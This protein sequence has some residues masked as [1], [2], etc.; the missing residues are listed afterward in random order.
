MANLTPKL[1]LMV[2]KIDGAYGNI[3]DYRSLV[4]QH[5]KMLVLTSPGERIMNP[6]Y[7][8]GIK[9]M[10]FEPN[11]QMLRGKISSRIY[12][13]AEKYLPYVAIN[14]VTFTTPEQFPN[15]LLVRLTYEIIPLNI[16]IE[17]TVPV[18]ET[19]F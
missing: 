9:R 12:S 18:V 5:M 15:T 2:D 8:V 11:D 3:K 14:S 4:A 16:T 19:G 13:Q 7:G 17:Q 10:L 1:P 6:D